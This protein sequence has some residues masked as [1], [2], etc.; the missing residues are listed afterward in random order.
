MNPLFRQQNN[1]IATAKINT[2]CCNF[3]LLFMKNLIYLIWVAKTSF[4]FSNTVSIPAADFPP[5]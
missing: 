3:I 1:K 4:A 5:A 2:N